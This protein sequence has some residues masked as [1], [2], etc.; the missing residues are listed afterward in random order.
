ETDT[1]TVHQHAFTEQVIEAEDDGTTTTEVL[2]GITKVIEGAADKTVKVHS[3]NLDS[4]SGAPG[5]EDDDY[6]DHSIKR[7]DEDYDAPKVAESNEE[8]QLTPAPSNAGGVRE[9]TAEEGEEGWMMMKRVDENSSSTASL[10]LC[11]A[12]VFLIVRLW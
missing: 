4:D 12:T 1:A 5:F 7:E 8:S 11:L 2:R 3:L 9:F 10:T 6:W